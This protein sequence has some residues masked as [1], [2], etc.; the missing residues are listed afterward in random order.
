MAVIPLA[1][2]TAFKTRTGDLSGKILIQLRSPSYCPHPASCLPVITVILVG[3]KKNILP[4]SVDN[5]F[6]EG[7]TLFSR[8][9]QAGK[10]PATGT[11]K[12]EACHHPAGQP[13]QRDRPAALPTQDYQAN[14][15]AAKQRANTVL[16]IGQK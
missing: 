10:T 6:L 2:A 5:Y 12:A 1:P 8:V 9:G 7:F 11:P 3:I 15:A 13:R 14:P 4:V 16:P